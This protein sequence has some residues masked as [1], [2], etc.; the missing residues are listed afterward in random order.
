MLGPADIPV[1]RV[2]LQVHELSDGIVIYDSRDE[3]VYSFN[4]TAGAV[5][6]E[7]NGTSTVADIIQQIQTHCS[8]PPPQVAA[9]VSTTLAAMVSFGLLET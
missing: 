5:W 1:P 4:I 9:D 3:K 8:A 2:D 6:Q 7:C